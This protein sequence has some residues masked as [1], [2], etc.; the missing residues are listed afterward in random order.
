MIADLLELATTLAERGAGPGRPKSVELR[1]AV[2]T[3]YYALFHALARLCAVKLVGWSKPWSVISPIYRSIDHRRT[4]DVLND[5]RKSE[6]GSILAVVSLTFS[7]L[8]DA[9]HEADY[10]P[11]PFRFKRSGTIDL[12]DTARQAIALLDGLPAE[13]RLALAVRLIARTR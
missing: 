7:Q 6:P 12:I 5:F 9:R 2:S 11:A 3:V 8:Q 10:N 4:R 13:A 1:R